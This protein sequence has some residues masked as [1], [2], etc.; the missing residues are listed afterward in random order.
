M[1][2]SLHYY[3]SI[4]CG[5]DNTMS[6]AMGKSIIDGTLTDMQQTPNLGSFLSA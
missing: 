4:L 6:S 1:L 5:V 2:Q 3:S